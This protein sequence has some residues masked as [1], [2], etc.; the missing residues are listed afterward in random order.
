METKLKSI[1]E[2]CNYHSLRILQLKE[3]KKYKDR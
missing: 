1:E 3:K 2:K